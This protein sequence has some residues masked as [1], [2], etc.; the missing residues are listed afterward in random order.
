M[1]T[2]DTGGLLGPRC[3]PSHGG[4]R[5]TMRNLRNGTSAT[6]TRAGVSAVLALAA[7]GGASTASFAAGGTT[8]GGQTTMA[9]S[10]NTGNGAT[11]STNTVTATLPSTATLKFASGAVSVQFQSIPVT[12]AATATCSTNPSAATTSVTATVRW[13]STTKIFVSVDNLGGVAG[14][15]GYWLACAYNLPASAN[16]ST[17]VIPSTATVIAKA[18]YQIAAAPTLAGSN[19]VIPA[20]GPTSGGQVVTISGTNFPTSITAA[21]PLSAT[22]AGVPLTNITPVSSSKFTAV[23]PVKPTTTNIPVLQVTTAGGTI[24][25]TSTVYTYKDGI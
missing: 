19:V 16:N 24:S 1:K 9:L 11:T 6:L 8:T 10:S 2:P 3:H 12:G 25:S 15:T 22:F 7:V 18:N 13:L 5:T 21:T 17:G 20:T 4:E 23:T 14:Q